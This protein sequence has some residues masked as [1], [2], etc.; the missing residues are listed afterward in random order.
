[1]TLKILVTGANGFIGHRL[2]KRFMEEGYEVVGSGRGPSVLEAKSYIY[3]KADIADPEACKPLVSGVEAVVHCAGKAGAW[4]Q[5]EAYIKANVQ[6]TEN[7]LAAC[8]TQGVGRFINLSSPSIYFD[9]R[10]QFNLTEEQLPARFSNAYA[11][12]KYLAEQKAQASHSSSMATVSLRPRGVIGA[13]DK[14]WLPRIIKMRAENRL[15]QPGPGKAL[16]DFTSVD[17]L[18]DLIESCLQADPAQLGRVYNVS[19]GRPENLWSFIEKALEQVGL[20]GRRRRVPVALAMSLA[21]CSEKF[22]RI[23]GSPYE[24]NLLPLKVGVAA[25]SMTLNIEAARKNLGYRPRVSTEEAVHEFAKW[26]RPR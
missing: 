3:R 10:D 6:G 14:N 13:G 21:R 22:H 18:I 11:E 1:M 9:F 12:T 17:N 5:R 16:V 15:I 25:Y 2:V 23:K 7:L 20:D 19:N 24:P 4:G 8:K 26:W